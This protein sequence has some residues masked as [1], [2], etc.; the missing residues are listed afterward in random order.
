MFGHKRDN[1]I[2]PNLS[3]ILV[4]L[5][6][7]VFWCHVVVVQPSGGGAGAADGSLPGIGQ[8]KA[9]IPVKVTNMQLA[10][11]PLWNGSIFYEDAAAQDNAQRGQQSYVVTLITLPLHEQYF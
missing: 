7:S 10:T 4:L 6:V 2:N 8:Y 5:I 9:Q 3:L 1:K 11:S